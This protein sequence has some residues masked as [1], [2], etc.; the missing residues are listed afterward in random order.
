MKFLPVFKVQHDHVIASIFL[1]CFSQ[2]LTRRQSRWPLHNR[3]S[4]WSVNHNTNECKDK[5]SSHL[6]IFIL[7]R[8]VDVLYLLSKVQKKWFFRTTIKRI[9]QLLY[10]W[11]YK[12]D[13]Q[14]SKEIICFPKQ[15]ARCKWYPVINC[16]MQY[17]YQTVR[18]M[19]AIHIKLWF[20]N[21]NF[22]IGK[23]NVTVKVNFEVT[24]NSV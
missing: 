5:F 18:N 1:D 20:C 13:S 19:N 23:G 17:H 11:V 3:C 24:Q 16:L 14:C 7:I 22:V 12:R 8:K 15:Y 9:S 10:H 6:K 4:Q 2:Q 21:Y